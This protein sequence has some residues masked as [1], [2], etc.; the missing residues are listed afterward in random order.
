V[1][2]GIYQSAAGMMVNEYRQN[3]IANNL[4]NA[5]TIGFKP[6]VPVFGERLRASLAGRRQ[7]P[8]NDLMEGLTGGIWLGR[9]E[10]DFSEST[11]ARTG[12]ACDVA[13]DG[14]GFLLVEKDGHRLLTRDGRMIVDPEG[15]LLAAT[16]GAAILGEGETP[17]RLNPRGGKPEIDIDGRISQDGLVVARLAV[18]DVDDYRALA[19]VGASRFLAADVEPVPAEAF[20]RSGYLENSGVRPV[21]TL[22]TMIEAARAY[23]INAQMISLQDQGLGRLINEVAR[24]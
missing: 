4:A 5:E 17:I 3:V 11:T 8:T 10:T 2:Y 18:V 9:T 20:V 1:I 7:G 21:Q 24:V 23:Q 19:R 16:D 14:P 15:R 22:T 12:N 6:Q 13:L